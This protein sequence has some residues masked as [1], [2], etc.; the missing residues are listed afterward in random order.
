M[1]LWKYFISRNFVS[2]L[3]LEITKYVFKKKSCC[4]AACYL[5]MK[6]KLCLK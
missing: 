5:V 3:F 4:V 1:L 2:I 6:N